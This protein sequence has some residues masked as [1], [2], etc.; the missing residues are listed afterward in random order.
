MWPAQYRAARAVVPH[1]LNELRPTHGLVALRCTL[2]GCTKCAAFEVEGR[3]AFEVALGAVSVLPWD[4]AHARRRRLAEA[5]G[6][7]DLPAYVLLR[8]RKAK[9]TVVVPPP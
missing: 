6:V 1:S 3:D 5:A 2:P 7:D 4:C 8:P 9:I